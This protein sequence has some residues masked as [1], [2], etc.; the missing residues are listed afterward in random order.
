MLDRK[1]VRIGVH[2]IAVHQHLEGVELVSRILS[3]AKVFAVR[4][5]KVV[6]LSGNR[7]QGLLNES[8]NRIDTVKVA[9]PDPKRIGAA[10]WE[11]IG[12]PHK[13]RVLEQRRVRAGP[14]GARPSREI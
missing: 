12:H 2:L 8:K 9:C 11:N 3:A 10:G 4:E 5:G 7:R 6:Y 14:A 13:L 1:E